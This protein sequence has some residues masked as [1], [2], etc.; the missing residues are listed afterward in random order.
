[1]S[2]GEVS[3]KISIDDAILDTSSATPSA[4][5]KDS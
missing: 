1:M 2:V 5:L 4:A 3:R